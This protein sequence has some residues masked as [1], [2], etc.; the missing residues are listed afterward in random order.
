VGFSP[1]DKLEDNQAPDR[2]IT[3]RVAGRRW[4]IVVVVALLAAMAVR[5]LTRPEELTHFQR[6]STRVLLIAVSFQFL[7][8][9]LWNGSMLLPLQIHM[10]DL[11][12]WELFMI[13]AG[14]VLAGYVVPVAGNL[15]VRLMYLKRRGLSYAEFTWATV[16]SNVLALF[17]GAMLAVVA[18]GILWWKLGTP[19]SAVLT[20][21]A[22]VL[23][24]GIA[25]L[26]VFHSLPR[27][28]G[29][30]RVQRWPW[31]SGLSTFQTSGRTMGGA[32]ALLLMRHCLNFLTF[33]LLFQSL[34][35]AP[36]EFVTGG[37]VYA[38]SS[39]MRMIALTPGNL[40]VDEWVVAIVG[41]I[42]TVEL[43]TGLIVAL[44]FRGVSL[45]AQVL[46]VLL[47]GAWLALWSTP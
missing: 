2:P 8:Q 12:F 14:G 22:T 19:S 4:L 41:R 37:L 23:A 1:I 45:V 16:V 44:V 40:G 47:G 31:I 42:L 28:A 13:R 6:L 21:T 25:S 29:H 32:L 10:K 35:R 18:V 11:G 5:L 39:P 33:G 36:L 27:L 34:S 3:R 7:S 30:A 26:V 17:S 20:L 9:L 46:G 24:L 43:T 15:A 38:I